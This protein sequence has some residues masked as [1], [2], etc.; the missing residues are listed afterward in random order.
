MSSIAGH[1][2]T[3]R[4]LYK[5]RHS[6]TFIAKA[7]GVHT[8]SV[9]QK[10]AQMGL[11]ERIHPKRVTQKQRAEIARLYRAK[12][13][14]QEI[15]EQFGICR[16][17]VL[18][19]SR[20]LGCKIQPRGQRYRA[21]ND[22]QLKRMATLWTQGESQ[23]AIA[24]KFG[25]SQAVISR[26]LRGIG[27]EIKPRL[28]RGARHGLWKDGRT[29]TAGGYVLVRMPDDRRFASMTNR[30]GY[31]L[32]HRLVMAQ[33]LGRALLV[34]ETVHHINGIKTD[35]RPGNLQLRQGRHGKGLIYRCARCGSRD[36]IVDELI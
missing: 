14:P 26:L 21:F 16:Q 1:E 25:V 13:S 4:R 5:K 29:I 8:T 28:A 20:S 6:V 11:R 35:N 24:R 19:I 3:I 9:S 36:L 15:Q 2:A 32:E 27:V 10:L 33:K 23:F 34:N 18:D 12:K 22:R 7:I 30:S 31:V 17:T